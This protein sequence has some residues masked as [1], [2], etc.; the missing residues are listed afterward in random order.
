MKK[1]IFTIATITCFGFASA[2]AAE[3]TN[4]ATVSAKAVNVAAL[5]EENAKLHIEVN[6]LQESVEDLKS[7]LN[8]N[9]AMQATMNKLQKEDEA[10]AKENAEALKSY[11]NLMI[12]TISRLA[13]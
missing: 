4:K 8:Y 2:N 13:N 7:T 9:K 5:V 11:N 3:T 12:K 6:Q 10:T 1:L